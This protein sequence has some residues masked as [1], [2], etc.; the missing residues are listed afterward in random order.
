[1]L[2]G[3]FPTTGAIVLAIIFFMASP[4][5]GDA[6]L[7]VEGIRL[8]AFH[9]GAGIDIV[10]AEILLTVSRP[11]VVLLEGDIKT[12]PLFDGQPYKKWVT[13][14][15]DGLVIHYEGLLELTETKSVGDEIEIVI[16]HGGSETRIVAE[17][18]GA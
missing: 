14:S 5:S 17:V 1:M 3:S 11:V 16:R 15:G 10:D 9:D 8:T 4:V 12:K 18:G 2:I 7:D 6:D 13:P